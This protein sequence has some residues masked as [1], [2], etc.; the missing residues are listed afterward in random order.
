M[1][2][3][4]NESSE[5]EKNKHEICKKLKKKDMWEQIW[6]GNPAQTCERLPPLRISCT[7]FSD[8]I[9]AKLV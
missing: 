7:V 4:V 6:N 9:L 8:R 1:V 5:L 3:K 2:S